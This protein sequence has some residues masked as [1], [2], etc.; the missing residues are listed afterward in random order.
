MSAVR[1]C[2]IR[3]CLEGA[4]PAVL[5]T[6]DAQGVPNVTYLSQ[7]FFVDEAHVA[8][9]FQFFN[10]TRRNILANPRATALLIHPRSA[11]L[12]RLHLR[13]LRT[14]SEGALFERMKAQLAGIASHTGMEGVFKLLGSDI[15]E[16]ELVEAVAGQPLPAPAASPGRLAVLR[17]GAERLARCT[18]LDA[19]LD[20]VL[21]TLGDGLGIRHAMVLVL[22]AKHQRLYTVASCGYPTSGVGSEI[23]VGQGVIGVAAR[24]RVPVR[25]S[26]VTTAASYS[27]ALRGS[28]GAGSLQPP[29]HEIPYPGLAQPH[30]QLAVP[31]LS[32]DRLLGVLFVESPRE[33]EFG[34]EDEDALVALAGHL[35]AAMELLQVAGEAENVSTPPAVAAP[36]PRGAMRLR[37]FHANDSIF[38][39]DTYLIKGVAGAILWKLARDHVQQGRTDFSNREL[40]LDATL[41]LPDVTDNLEAR[42]LLLQRRLQE[43]GPHLRIEKTGRGRFRLVV[44]RTLQLAEA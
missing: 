31:I 26:H 18:S 36:A 19:A 22:D 32:M 15:Y 38:I 4:I 28:V 44:G 12:F 13:Y 41:G 37:R 11:G 14:E 17:T 7:V 24:E 10:K 35:G 27:Q 39:D 6:S 40:R 29:A 23:L 20:A 34:F 3:D 8:L 5:A 2:D 16:V 43:H 21:A 1:L 42:L 30:S 25:I 33:L 9:S